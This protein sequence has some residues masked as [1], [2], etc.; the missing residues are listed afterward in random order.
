MPNRIDENLIV[1]YDTTDDAAVYK[2]SDD[3]A[4]ILT[5]DFF[6][7]MIEDPYQFGQVAAANSLSDVYAMGGKPIIS[8]NIVG[9][10]QKSDL[11]VLGDILRGGADKAIEAESSIAGGHTIDIDTPIYGLAVAGIVHPDKIVQNDNT[12]VGDALILTKPL[13]SGLIA[14]GHKSGKASEEVLQ[15]AIKHMST[16]NKYAGEVMVR[17]N[18]NS[19][20]DI[21]GF[22]FLGH[23]D[24]MLG[25]KTGV[26]VFLDNVPFIEGAYEVAAQG[27]QTGGGKRNRQ[28]IAHKIEY[29]DSVVFDEY[30]DVLLHDPQTSGG[31][32]V[33]I[34]M[35]E[36]DDFISDL[37]DEGIESAYVGRI[38]ETG[39][40]PI[41][42]YNSENDL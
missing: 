23:L 27:V 26:D 17:H 1:G 6:P 31:L 4:L 37:K 21:T 12:Q 7:P 5:T 30:K 16:L 20:T 3:I 38:R 19:A 33:S 36:K 24:E 42:I 34:P 18:V 15:E 10:P 11:T 25:G 39:D 22:G 28:H 29:A 35:E 14:S 40:K 13:G 32:L 8:L 2:L 41:R 9:Y